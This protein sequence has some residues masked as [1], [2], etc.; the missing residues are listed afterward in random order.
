MMAAGFGPMQPRI[1]PAQELFPRGAWTEATAT[2]S[3]RPVNQDTPRQRSKNVSRSFRL[4]LE[5]SLVAGPPIAFY[6][7]SFSGML[8]IPLFRA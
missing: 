8:R 7:S 3:P 6:G 4:R 1:E 5:T 2:G